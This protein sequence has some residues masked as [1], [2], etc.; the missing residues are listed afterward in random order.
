MLSMPDCKS[1]GQ[2]FAVEPSSFSIIL[3]VHAEVRS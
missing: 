2:T 1:Q 3:L